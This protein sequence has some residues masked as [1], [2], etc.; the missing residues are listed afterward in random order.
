M[1]VDLARR[2]TDEY[3]IVLVG[4]DDQID[5]QLPDNVI[6]IH[7]TQNQQE[8]AQIYTA[9]DVFV[10]PTREE[11]YPTVNME[12]IACGT[13]VLTFRTGGSPEIVGEACGAVVDCD[14]VEHLE[15][16]IVSICKEKPHLKE[17]CIKQ[18]KEFDQ[19]E[20]FKE[21]MELYE[22]VNLART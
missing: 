19:N 11:N 5:K 1:F 22:R 2:L 18:S 9:A 3:R 8:L 7:R 21:Y 13:P 17:A 10:I 16:E 12:A 20:R 4:T 14:D 15:K 6:S